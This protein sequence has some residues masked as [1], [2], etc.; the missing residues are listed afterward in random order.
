MHGR[1]EHAKWY[2][3]VDKRYITL[4]HLFHRYALRAQGY[5]D[6]E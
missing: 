2:E 5:C 4:H 1:E 6:T 3:K